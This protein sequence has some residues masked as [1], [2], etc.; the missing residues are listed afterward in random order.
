VLEPDR[1]IS[2][3]TVVRKSCTSKVFT[4]KNSIEPNKRNFIA[5]QKN[6]IAKNTLKGHQSPE[7]KTQRNFYKKSPD[8]N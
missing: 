5:N 8:Q 2:R 7:V 1:K 3:D 6:F 4:S